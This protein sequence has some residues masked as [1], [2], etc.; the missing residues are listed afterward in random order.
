MEK[1]GR[2]RKPI[3]LNTEQEDY[4]MH[5]FNYSDG[6]A[7][8]DEMARFAGELGM[9]KIVITDHAQ[10]TFEREGY[11]KKSS[12]RLIKE[13]RWKNVYNNVE[14]SFGVEADLLNEQGDIC[15]D[16]QGIRMPGEFIILSYHEN[17]YNGDKEKVTEAFI[18]AIEKH[19]KIISCIGHLYLDCEKIDLAKVVEQANKFRIPLEL[20]CRYLVSG[21]PDVDMNALKLMLDQ[22]DSI[23]VNSDAHT[24]W[25]LKEL[26][27]GGFKFLKENGFLE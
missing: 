14:V 21:R 10:T 15:A 25:E 13:K 6:L 1:P 4:H 22:A 19:H 18:N 5:S 17:T 9:K 26:R 16:I 24:L 12:R 3:I 2:I 7:T 20:N 8:I 27:K 11:F 23:Y